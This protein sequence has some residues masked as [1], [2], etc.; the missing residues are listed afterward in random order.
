[1]NIKMLS[2]LVAICC[3]FL[4]TADVMAAEGKG[5]NQD[6]PPPQAQK[7][8]EDKREK[9]APP[10]K[11]KGPDPSKRSTKAKSHEPKSKVPAHA[12][13]K[14]RSDNKRKGPPEQKQ[15]NAEGK[16]PEHAEE[17]KPSIKKGS[18]KKK[19]NVEPEK[20]VESK[21]IP[22]PPPSTP[23]DSVSQQTDN[24][25]EDKEEQ[26]TSKEEPPIP[27]L[28][29]HPFSDPIE[30][31]VIIPTSP[32]KTLGKTGKDRTSADGPINWHFVQTS[33]TPAQPSLHHVMAS[34]YQ[35]FRNQWMNAPPGEPPRTSP[36]FL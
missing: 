10:E 1:M 13:Q 36:L 32:Q 7:K 21:G 27:K 11:A 19:A 2:I 5:K 4:S 3:F 29:P 8:K 15:N 33:D 12:Q 17:K 25:L 6:G 26:A 14:N 34:R 18:Q 31:G 20:K 16:I 9:P 35:M 30:E 24:S 28:P 22:S 23:A